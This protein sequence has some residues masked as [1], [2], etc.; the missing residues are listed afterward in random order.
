MASNPK[1]QTALITGAS[2]GLGLA[3]ARGLAARGWNLI[4]TGRDPERLRTVRNELAAITHVAALAGD[5]TDPA[6]RKQLAVLARGHTGLDALVN[7]A[8][9]LGPSPQPGLL[10]YPLDILIEVYL[11]NVIAP[12][13]LIQALRSDLK[14]GARIINV[15]SDAGVT[16]YPGW[17]GYGSSKAA[18]EQL[19]AVLATENPDL[20]V[21]WVDHGDMR[22]DM[23]QAAYPGEDISDRPLPDARVPGFVALLEG[24]FPSGRYAAAELAP[25]LVK[26]R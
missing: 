18:L 1:E 26:G 2:R 15:T 14:E 25:A 12:L 13:G 11:A 7:N 16:P 21:Y 6:H 5:I 8:G 24:D 3:L 4:L 10:D 19:S 22:T 17:G 23:H 9:L 20:K